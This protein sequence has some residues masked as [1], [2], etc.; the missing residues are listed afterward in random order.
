MNLLNIITAILAITSTSV[1][2]SMRSFIDYMHVYN[3]SYNDGEFLNRYNNYMDNTKLIDTHNNLNLSWKM[4]INHFTDMSRQEFSER[5][6]KFTIDDREEFPFTATTTNI[7]NTLPKKFDWSQKGVVSAVKNQGQCGSCWSFST[8]GS[9]ESANAIKT[10]KLVTLS[11]QQFMDCSTSYGNNGCNGGLMDDAFK[12]AIKNSIC[13]EK[14]YPYEAKDD[15]CKSKSCDGVV[16]LTGYNDVTPNDEN[17]LLQALSQQPISIAIEADKYA[18]QFYKSGVFDGSCGTN[19][20]HGVLL[21]GWGVDKN[22]KKYW[23]IKNSWGPSWGDNGYIL[24][25]RDINDER[26]QCGV[27][28]TPSYPIV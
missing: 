18:F 8:T 14:A 5:Y 24:I 22:N 3:K 26:G 7:S 15:S 16:Q 9:I 11:E 20:D 25:A 1:T 13:T 4:G 28:M 23:K 12:Y 21:V 27:A 17:A 10:G 2:A 19:L 6:G